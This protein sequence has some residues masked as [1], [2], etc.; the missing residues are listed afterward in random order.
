MLVHAAAG[1][2]ESVFQAPAF[3]MEKLIR[4]FA[5][6]TIFLVSIRAMRLFVRPGVA[7]AAPL[8][9]MVMLPFS[10][11]FLYVTDELEV[12]GAWLLLW[13]VVKQRHGWALAVMLFFTLNREL[14]IFLGPWY[15]F[16]SMLRGGWSLKNPAWTYSALMVVGVL[17]V[18][19]ILVLLLGFS[20]HDNGVYYRY[21]NLKYIYAWFDYLSP[22]R[23]FTDT[24]LPM[25]EPL[26]FAPGSGWRL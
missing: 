8:A 22:T 5:T 24:C 9:H 25:A 2:L 18:H 6:F 26:K 4:T 19:F 20:Y 3:F 13:A 12:L 16:Y 17:G 11:L 1:A 15:W 23:S 21:F 14:L 10:Y 7:L